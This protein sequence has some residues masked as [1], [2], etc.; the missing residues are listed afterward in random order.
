M[1]DEAKEHNFRR[2]KILPYHSFEFNLNGEKDKIYSNE[3]L[4]IFLI[5]D[6]VFIWYKNE[7]NPKIALN[8]LFRK[9]ARK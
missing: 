1:E 7:I 2:K 8:S 3:E 4:A 9:S 6:F 5:S